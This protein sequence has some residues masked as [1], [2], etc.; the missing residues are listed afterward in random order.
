MLMAIFPIL[1]TLAL[2]CSATAA[3]KAEVLWTRTIADEGGRYAGWPTLTRLRNGELRVVYSGGREAHICP[4]GKVRMIRSVDGGETWS[5]PETIYD[6]AID[7]R[8]AALLELK[9][10]TL[11]VFWFT[12][13]DFGD[14]K[15]VPGE[16]Y[17]KYWNTLDK[18]AVRQML[19][20]FCIRS[21]D[22]GKTWSNPV[23]LPAMTPHGPTL[24]R[25]GRI[26][27]VGMQSR[28]TRGHLTND[29]E[30]KSEPSHK[31]IVVCESKDGGL[32]WQTVTHISPDDWNRWTIAEPTV[33]EAK[34][35]TLCA[36]FRYHKGLAHLLLSES[37]DGGR[38]WSQLKETNVDGYPP[39]I[40]RLRDGRT[41][42]TYARRKKGSM[43]VFAAIGM[44]DG[45]TWDVANELVLLRDD[46]PDLGYAT[47]AELDDGTLLTVFY[48]HPGPRT[49]AVIQAVKW[50][51]GAKLD[52]VS[53]V[54]VPSAAM[55]KDV[56]TTVMFPSGYADSTPRRYPVVY[57]LHGAGNDQRTYACE[58]IISLADRIGAIVVSPYGGT[59]WW[60]DSPR[61]PWMRYETFVAEELVPYVDGHYRTVADRSGRAIAGHSM[62]G[63][64]ACFIGFGHTD[65]FG[66][67]GNVMGGV[68][69]CPFATRKDLMKL[70]G[71]KNEY[72]DDWNRFSAMTRAAGLR[73]GEV[74]FTTIVG[75][76]DFFLDVNR[77]LHGLL[78]SNGVAHV[79]Q[80]IRGIDE[81]HSSHT[82]TFAYEAMNT[83]FARFGEYFRQTKE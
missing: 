49:P 15:Y 9:D 11:L 44:D 59:S 40:L 70:L 42:L 16:R 19:G 12:D 18:T 45:R 39:H 71:E 4:W 24:L 62:G 38:T 47:T 35:G 7:D 50:R 30:E 25:D 83:V 80:E 17:Q 13:V 77:A 8:D 2:A 75:T 65:I 20:S 43:G 67:V 78:S 68:D 32:T 73:N 51:L 64:G 74:Q 52:L 66:A 72:P 41:L 27:M 63:H 26:L 55:K 60:I 82:R 61:M 21:T 37:K 3:P 54:A 58:P 46:N 76:G 29:P 23:R 34:D 79:Y 22:G 36:Y 1:A 10:G 28:Y 57:L 53:E 81:E 56:P 6:C 69:L 33:H 5:K 31:K 48:R 14:P